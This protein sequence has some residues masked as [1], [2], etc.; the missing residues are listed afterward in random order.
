MRRHEE[1]LITG[2]DDDFEVGAF[3]PSIV[4]EALEFQVTAARRERIR[5]VLDRRLQSVTVV[6]DNLHDP[7]NGAAIVRSCD[8][9]GVQTMHAIVSNE[10]FSAARAV[11]RGSQKWV[12]I[13]QHRTA[14]DCIESLHSEGFVMVATHPEGALL[15]ADLASISRVAL[16]L[17]N[18]RDG[19][20]PALSAACT[21]AVRVPMVGFV[22]S[23][24]V[25][26]T[27]A[28]LLHAACSPRPGDLAPAHW[29]ALYA[30]ALWL[31][32]P[33]ARERMEAFVVR[34]GMRPADS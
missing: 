33:R 21:Q 6:V 8:A 32:V 26:V 27:T 24:N 34:A 15:P 1:D 18:E 10:P 30:R 5:N 11:A 20:S 31:T 19:I 23:L 9:F 14:L 29:Q 22:E 13:D 3:A 25:S 16:V 2:D 7:H 17:G 4:I 12:Q 28:I